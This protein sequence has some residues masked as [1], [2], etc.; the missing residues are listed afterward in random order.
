MGNITTGGRCYDKDIR[1]IDVEYYLVLPESN[2]T[3]T[4][5]SSVAKQIIINTGDPEVLGYTG[6]LKLDEPIYIIAE[7][8]ISGVLLRKCR[9]RFDIYNNA[10][11]LHDI[12]LNETKS[13][14]LLPTHTIVDDTYTVSPHPVMVNDIV[15][16]VIY[17][18]YY[19]GDNVSYDGLYLDYVKVATLRKDETDLT[20]NFLR[21]G[22]F[23]LG[24]EVIGTNYEVSVTKYIDIDVSV[25][26]VI[27][28]TLTKVK[29][30]V[31]W[32]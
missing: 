31:E 13:V 22:M 1:P 7:Q 29:R 25:D 4:S 3:T 18:L 12:I 23:R 17:T 27:A 21:S 8:V 11:V 20:M 5:K 15:T 28:T 6:T 16:E 9:K 26:V 30:Y 2:I 10:V 14:D 19:S 32:E 24:I